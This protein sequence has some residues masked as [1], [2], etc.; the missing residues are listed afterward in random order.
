MYITDTSML[1]KFDLINGHKI[2]QALQFMLDIFEIRH[3]YT[4]LFT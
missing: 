1:M 3:T 4:C 2:N